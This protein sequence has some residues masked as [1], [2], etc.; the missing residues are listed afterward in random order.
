MGDNP[1][2][3]KATMAGEDVS[4]LVHDGITGFNGIT[5]D[6]TNELIYWVDTMRD[7]IERIG[8]NGENRQRVY[9][10]NGFQIISLAYYKVSVHEKNVGKLINIYTC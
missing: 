7:T 3:S 4:V 2:I 6:Y 1:M 8:Y 5:L 9:R 10:L